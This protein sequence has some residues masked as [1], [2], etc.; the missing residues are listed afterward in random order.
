MKWNKAFKLHKGKLFA[1]HTHTHTKTYW[2]GHLENILYARIMKPLF[3]ICY[4]PALTDRL[5][6]KVLCILQHGTTITT[7]T[8]ITCPKPHTKS[9]SKHWRSAGGLLTLVVGYM[10]WLEYLHI[11]SFWLNYQGARLKD[12]RRGWQTWNSK[13]DGETDRKKGVGRWHRAP[14]NDR[15]SEKF[16]CLSPPEYFPQQC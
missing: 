1:A 16:V 12:R 6:S 5:R 2:K 14:G 10:N 7:Q 3:I 9:I 13:R 4:L 11:S 8:N 15:M